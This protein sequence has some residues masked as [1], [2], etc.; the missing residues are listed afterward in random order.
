VRMPSSPGTVSIQATSV[1]DPTKS[2]SRSIAVASGLGNTV[3]TI[4]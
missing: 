4:R 2:A 3:G 1:D